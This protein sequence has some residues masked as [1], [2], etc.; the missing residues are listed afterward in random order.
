[1]SDDT[2][3]GMKT[4]SFDKKIENYQMWWMRFEA[5]VNVKN[6]ERALEDDVNLPG[7]A[8]AHWI[9]K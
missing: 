4:H 9:Q 5:F 7:I 8:E 2:L 1:M 3:T 6:I